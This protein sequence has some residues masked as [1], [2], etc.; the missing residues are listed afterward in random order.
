MQCQTK[1]IQNSKI[2]ISPFP[3]RRRKLNSVMPSLLLS[4]TIFFFVR[5]SLNA[6]FLDHYKLHSNYATT[7]LECRRN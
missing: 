7:M 2:P 4:E 1:S 5:V 3:I 6:L